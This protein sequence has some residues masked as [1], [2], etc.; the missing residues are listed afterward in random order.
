[1]ILIPYAVC[2]FAQGLAPKQ[3]AGLLHVVHAVADAALK[4]P[5]SL[6]LRLLSAADLSMNLKMRSPSTM[7]LNCVSLTEKMIGC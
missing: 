6:H 2:N 3:T 4:M 5:S 7:A 1:M